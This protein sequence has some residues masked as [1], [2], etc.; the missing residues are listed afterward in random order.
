M[1]K[2]VFLVIFLDNCQKVLTNVKKVFSRTYFFQR[3]APGRKNWVS[4]RVPDPHRP[5][6]GGGIV[7]TTSPW[8]GWSDPRDIW[9][10]L[11]GEDPPPDTERHRE[12]VGPPTSKLER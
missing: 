3:K 2:I 4:R 11:R 9:D 6:R 10:D 8:S 1:P 12:G 5:R 7:W